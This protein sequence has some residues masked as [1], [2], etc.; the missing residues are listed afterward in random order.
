[1][2][3][4][5]E[6]EGSARQVGERGA[7]GKRERGRASDI[8]ATL[9]QAT[10]NDKRGDGW[11]AGAS[12]MPFTRQIQQPEAAN[13]MTATTCS[14]TNAYYLNNLNVAILSQN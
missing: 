10:M 11:A 9:G 6:G 3:I 2:C 7:G 1:M 8:E 13:E 12:L 5:R 14:S 4:R